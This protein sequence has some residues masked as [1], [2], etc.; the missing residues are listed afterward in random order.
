MVMVSL[1]SN[2][3]PKTEVGTRDWGITMIQ[4]I[5]FWFGV[6]WTLGVWVRKARE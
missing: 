3:N 2:R 1:H 6:I 5:I 4:Q